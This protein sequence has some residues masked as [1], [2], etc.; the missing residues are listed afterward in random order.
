MCVCVCV[1]FICVCV[2]ACVL[3][4]ASSHGTCYRYIIWFYST[5]FLRVAINFSLKHTHTEKI[6]T[7]HFQNQVRGLLIFF[8]QFCTLS[9]HV[10]IP[11]LQMFVIVSMYCTI[12]Y[13][14]ICLFFQIDSL[15]RSMGGS[16]YTLIL[17][18]CV[19]HTLCK[20]V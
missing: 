18:S 20:A 15:Y 9:I 3:D 8:K 6:S 10:L 5:L 12:M 14:V 1:C 7:W 16:M 4:V 11:V 13:I 2:C 17:F 19:F